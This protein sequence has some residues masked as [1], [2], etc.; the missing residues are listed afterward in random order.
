MLKANLSGF[1]LE[2]TLVSAGVDAGST[3]TW[4]LFVWDEDSIFSVCFSQ[5]TFWER[6]HLA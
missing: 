3:A 1:K 5:I 6:I 2:H 4:L